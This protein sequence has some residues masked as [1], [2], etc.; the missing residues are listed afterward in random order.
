MLRTY[1]DYHFS[2]EVYAELVDATSVCVE[3]NVHLPIESHTP[4]RLIFKICILIY[5]PHG[6]CP[7][8]F[9]IHGSRSDGKSCSASFEIGLAYIHNTQCVAWDCRE[10][11]LGDARVMWGFVMVS[12]WFIGIPVQ[13]STSSFPSVYC[14]R[15][16][17]FQ[18][19]VKMTPPQEVNFWLLR[20]AIRSGVLI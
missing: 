5:R 15:F 3:S 6:S 7:T 4:S 16:I 8:L 18:L 13:D 19:Q 1:I 12:C 14:L 10:S 9:H 17:K 11:L 2:W 20:P